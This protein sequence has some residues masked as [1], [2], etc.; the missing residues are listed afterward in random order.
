MEQDL[1]HLQGKRVRL[2]EMKDK[3]DPVPS[4]TEGVVVHTGGDVINVDWDNGRT[5]GLIY[6]EDHYT[7]LD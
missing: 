7:V 2:I 5:L 4:G 1:T 6:G 3:Y